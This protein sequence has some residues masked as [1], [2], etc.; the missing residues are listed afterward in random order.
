MLLLTVGKQM[1]NLLFIGLS[2][3]NVK[4]L[5]ITMWIQE[6]HIGFKVT[7]E[8]IVRLLSHLFRQ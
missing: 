4:F 6:F 1:K 2:K 8:T 5:H 7:I 3:I